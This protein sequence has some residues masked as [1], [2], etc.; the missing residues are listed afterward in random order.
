MNIRAALYLA[1]PILAACSGTLPRMYEGPI[2]AEHEVS[3]Y[4]VYMAHS[5]TSDLAAYT[6]SIDGENIEKHVAV[7]PGLGAFGNVTILP[8]EHTFRVSFK[9]YDNMW[10]PAYV[11]Q[12]AFQ[13]WYDIKATTKPGKYY[14]PRFR[15]ELGERMVDEICLVEVDPS[16]SVSEIRDSTNYV[17]CGKPTVAVVDK[18]VK[19]C[20]YVS[21]L[22]GLVR[23][24]AT[25]D[26]GK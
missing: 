8:G 6:I 5:F 12:K 20:Q 1:I 14:A 15:T 4:A 26:V 19:V 7:V 23:D 2:R 3:L 16:D 17:G 21:R 22:H 9:D 10:L 11:E 25:C 24:P 18:N 13:G